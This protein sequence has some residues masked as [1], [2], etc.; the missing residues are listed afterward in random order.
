MSGANYL[1]SRCITRMHAICSSCKNKPDTNKCTEK[2][3][4]WRSITNSVAIVISVV[5]FGSAELALPNDQTSA[6]ILVGHFS[7]L[8]GHFSML[9]CHPRRLITYDPIYISSAWVWL[10][11]LIATNKA[12][13][14]HDPSWEVD[15]LWTCS[16]NY[17][18]VKQNCNLVADFKK[19][20]GK[21][22]FKL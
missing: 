4:L 8:M 14:A 2:R 12:M 16:K 18:Q 1:W 6:S 5:A 15:K 17:I 3:F 9:V 11:R 10:H 13:L 19:Q 21:W 22:T 7:I 20:D